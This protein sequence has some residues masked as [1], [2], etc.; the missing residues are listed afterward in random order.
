MADREAD[1]ALVNLVTKCYS[2]SYDSMIEQIR[3]PNPF[4]GQRGYI[5]NPRPVYMEFY[6]GD[7][8]S[9]MGYMPEWKS[10]P[11][12]NLVM[13]AVEN[14]V[15]FVTDN[16]PTPAISPREENDTWLADI[17]GA[18]LRYWWA[19]ESLSTKVTQAV[20][21]SSILAVSW[22]H[23]PF[24]GSQKCIVLDTESVLVDPECTAENF[25]PT[26]L[27]YEWRGSFG[28][29]K[30]AYPK[31]DWDNFNDN[32]TPTQRG[33][34]ERVQTRFK[35]LLDTSIKSPVRTVS[36]YELWIKD[37][38]KEKFTE[39]IDDKTITRA[40]TKYPNGWR[41]I[42]FA[43]GLVLDDSP[44]K[45]KHGEVPFTPIFCYQVPGRFYGMGH[46]Q[47]LLP[48]QISHNR[49]NQL[50]YDATVKKGGGIIL[51]GA[52]LDLDKAAITN[53]PIQ[54]HNVR[55]VNQFR[56]A[57][58]PDPPRHVF[59]YLDKIEQQAQNAVGQHDISMG[60]QLSGNTTAQ[61][62]NAISQSDRTRVRSISR[63]LAWSLERMLRQ[64]VSNL[65]Q[66]ED[67]TWFLRIVGEDGSE[68]TTPFQPSK[69]LKKLGEDGK[70][71]A[72]MVEFDLRIEDSSML[73]DSAN[74]LKQ[75]ALNLF[76][77]QAMSKTTLMRTL[78]VTNP[79]REMQLIA[80]EQAQAQADAAKVAQEQ[81]AAQAP[82]P[83]QAPPQEM[84]PPPEAPPVEAPA[85]AP[86]GAPSFDDLPPE[87]QQ[88]V[89]EIAQQ[90]GVDPQA[91]IDELMA[92]T[93]M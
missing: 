53:A 50:L 9:R 90:G 4:P 5:D 59:N 79:Q 66:F 21:G 48:A 77:R 58:F 73:P 2:N 38:T 84:A 82:A 41:V 44:S 29:L 67:S 37:T 40:K 55:D 68:S 93:P 6:T 57:E 31:A 56:V 36:V 45:Y 12:S 61:E 80:S 24:E 1:S 18:G 88:K 39:D 11:V 32:W 64:V 19:K 69:M 92:G 14:Y 83:E 20:R 78:K 63:Q 42:T 34:V 87:L 62:V 49:M 85:G 75:Q 7:D 60:K 28:N 65:A 43:G 17:I 51:L 91:V 71:T 27:I 81:A 13:P 23:T 74:E 89:M 15:T 76:D 16:E 26:Y 86:T 52:G 30:S 47:A 10:R 54:V 72:D 22:L 35:Q 8:W 3:I 70:I 46:V 33:L 25:D